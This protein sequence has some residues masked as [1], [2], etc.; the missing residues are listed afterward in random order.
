MTTPLVE[1]VVDV[2]WG[3][4]GARVDVEEDEERVATSLRRKGSRHKGEESRIKLKE[5]DSKFLNSLGVVGGGGIVITGDP[6]AEEG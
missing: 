4:E 5:V 2:P 3:D 6:E 1:V